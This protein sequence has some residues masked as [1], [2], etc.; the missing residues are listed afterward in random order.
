MPGE[1]V[2]RALQHVW[3]TLEPLQAPMAV[4]GGL[5][6]AVWKHVRATRDVDLLVNLGSKDAD[7]VIALFQAAGVRPKRQPPILAVGPLRILQLLYE[8]PGTLVDLQIDVLLAESEYFQQALS[9]RI[10]ARLP[11]LDLEIAVLSCE[12]LILHKLIAGRIIDRLDAVALL[13]INGPGLDQEYLKEWVSRLSLT[14]EWQEVWKEAFPDT[15]SSGA[16]GTGEEATDQET[17]T[18]GDAAGLPPEQRE[19]ES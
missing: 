17:G 18:T 3:T 10:P 2:L 15:A 16:G 9:R 1:T 14:A 6:L 7:E 13:R 5:A 11:G 8:P 12:D 4:M 19:G